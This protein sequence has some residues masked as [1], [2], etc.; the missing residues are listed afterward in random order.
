VE[1]L[2]TL[3]VLGILRTLNDSRRK[4]TQFFN[5]LIVKDYADLVFDTLISRKATTGRLPLSGF[6]NNDE[7]NDALKQ[8]KDFYQEFLERIEKGDI[9]D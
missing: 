1:S 2:V 3:K 5:S 7:L 4:D 9:H 8:Y 6:D